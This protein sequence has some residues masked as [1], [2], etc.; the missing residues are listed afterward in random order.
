M[1][2]HATNLSPYEW[3]WLHSNVGDAVMRVNER[4]R[5]PNGEDAALKLRYGEFRRCASYGEN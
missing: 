2:A 1:D 5:C 3:G 4:K